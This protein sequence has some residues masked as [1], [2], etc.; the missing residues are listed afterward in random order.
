MKYK[1]TVSLGFGE[2][3]EK[4]FKTKVAALKFQAKI[5][6]EGGPKHFVKVLEKTSTYKEI[7]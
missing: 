3:Y 7:G 5:R 6:K 1:V 2:W 4:L